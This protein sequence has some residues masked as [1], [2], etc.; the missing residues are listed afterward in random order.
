MVRKGGT[1]RE[2]AVNTFVVGAVRGA[3]LDLGL[4]TGAAAG[5]RLDLP[6][7]ALEA[8][9]GILQSS[10][11]PD[12]LTLD[13]R[14][15]SASLAAYRAFDLGPVTVAGG[16]EAGGALL[17]QRFHE[18]QTP[19]RRA[20]AL[21]VGPAAIVETVLSGPWTLRLDSAF[22]TYVLPGEGDATRA[23]ATF[24]AGVGLGH[25]F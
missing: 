10:I 23:A 25:S 8:R 16:V 15:L 5:A 2:L 7:L 13:T 9:V 20:R 11:A 22:L 19:D 18:R 21:S 6:F 4:A 3:I 1:E 12:R 14:E 17:D 24:R